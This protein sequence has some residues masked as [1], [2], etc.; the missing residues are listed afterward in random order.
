MAKPV[1]SLKA[2]SEILLLQFRFRGARDY[3]QGTDL[4]RALTDATAATGPICLEIHRVIRCNAEAFRA[5]EQNQH[6]PDLNN[7]AATFEYGS[8]DERRCVFVR[9]RP[10]LKIAIREPY[11]EQAI[12]ANAV[13]NNGEILSDPPSHG[14]F[15]ERVLALNKLLLASVAGPQHEW[16][17]SR[18]NL[19]SM[20]RDECRLMLR[21]AGSFQWKLTKTLI[22]AD[23]SEAGEVYFSKRS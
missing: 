15:V 9:E 17:F 16:W 6:R 8:G 10:D 19:A 3:V 18:L 23:G 12:V 4:F 22:I 20:Q 14:T 13:L 5:D 11:D 1:M 2:D 21:F 7:I